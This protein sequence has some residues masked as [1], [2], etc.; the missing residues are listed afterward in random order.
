MNEGSTEHLTA[1]ERRAVQ[2]FVRSLQEQL[3]DQVLEATL[4]G[5][6]ARGDSSAWSDIDI[7]ITVRE[8]SW[9]IRTQVSTLAA[10]ISLEYDVLIGPRVIGQERWERMK[11]AGFGLYNN[12]A[13]DGVPL[14]LP[15]SEAA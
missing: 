11:K 8:E 13:A 5:S 9:P 12:I 1:R 2:A 14:H 7:L 15:A 4:F 3:A 6:K 10:D